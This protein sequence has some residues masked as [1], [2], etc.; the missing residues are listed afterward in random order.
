MSGHSQ[1]LAT[2][3]ALPGP[4]AGAEQDPGVRRGALR[5]AFSHAYSCRAYAE[6][7]EQHVAETNKHF[8]QP[9]GSLRPRCT[10][11]TRRSSSLAGR[12]LSIVLLRAFARSWLRTA[13]GRTRSRYSSAS[14]PC[15][16]DSSSSTS[17]CRGTSRARTSMRPARFKFRLKY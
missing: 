1:G 6:E 11:T 14:P 5:H 8:P 9:T 12:T 16:C 7:L 2:A 4:R 10:M 3:A 17:C 15:S 13:L